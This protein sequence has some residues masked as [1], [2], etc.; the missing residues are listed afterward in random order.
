MVREILDRDVRI[1]FAEGEPPGHYLL[2]PFTFKPE[3]AEKLIANEFIEFGHGLLDCIHEQ[4]E[5]TVAAQEAG[6]AA[7]SAAE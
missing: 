5:T 6:D 7:R 2:T 4:H 1:E 3:M